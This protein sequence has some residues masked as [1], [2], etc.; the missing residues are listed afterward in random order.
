M[1]K[2]MTDEQR[3]QR[4][5]LIALGHLASVIDTFEPHEFAWVLQESLVEEFEGDEGDE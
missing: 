3:E 1:M 4:A 5:A 2:N